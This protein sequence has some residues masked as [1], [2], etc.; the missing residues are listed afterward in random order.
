MRAIDD[1]RGETRAWRE[2]CAAIEAKAAAKAR[3]DYLL[4]ETFR[5]LA[6]QRGASIPQVLQKG[7]K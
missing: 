3:E 1:A 4:L 7:V 2:Q 5:Q 6:Y